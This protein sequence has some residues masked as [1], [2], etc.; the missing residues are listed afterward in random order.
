MQYHVLF[1]VPVL[2]VVTPV[3]ADELPRKL[4]PVVVW[5]GTDSK[6]AKM[7][8]ARCCSQKEWQTTWH[9]HQSSTAKAKSQRCPEVDFDSYMVV[10]I[11]H[12][13]SFQNT[14]IEIVT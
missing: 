9:K 11:F 2:L 12:G 6:Q 14:G 3:S 4:K 10:V 5:T 1:L 13:E 8:F 7:S